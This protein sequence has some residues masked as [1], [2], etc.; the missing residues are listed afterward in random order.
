MSTEAALA[1]AVS[2]AVTYLERLLEVTFEALDDGGA[3]VTVHGL[4]VGER[5]VPQAIDLTFEIPFNY[6]FAPIYPYYTVPGLARADGSGQ[7]P[8]LQRVDWRGSTRTQ[9]SLRANRWNPQVDNAVG[10]ILQVQRW[11]R[12]T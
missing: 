9:I 3:I 10:A 7:P 12:N 4:D 1:D 6:P 2:D 8:G 11:L 5:W